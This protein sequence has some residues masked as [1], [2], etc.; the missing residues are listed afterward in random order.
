MERKKLVDAYAIIL[1]SLCPLLQ[2]PGEDE[3]LAEHFVRRFI[4]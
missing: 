1:C 3:R 2:R 4:E